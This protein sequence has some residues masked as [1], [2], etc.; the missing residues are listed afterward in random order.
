MSNPIITTTYSKLDF[1]AK[2]P[3][4]GAPPPDRFRCTQED[5]Y[6]IRILEKGRFSK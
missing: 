4:G 5:N 1:W 2:E 6:Y 3:S